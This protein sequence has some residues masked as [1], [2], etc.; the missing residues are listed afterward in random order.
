MKIKD[1]IK[2]RREQLNLSQEQIAKICGVS[3][4][5]VS[6]WEGGEIENMKIDKIKALASALCIEPS[7]LIEDNINIDIQP[8]M[9]HDHQI[10]LYSS[11]S[12]GLGMFIS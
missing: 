11:V 8:K 2:T 9:I 12:C 7:V 3:K 4:G 1:Y 10:P 5:T 6:R